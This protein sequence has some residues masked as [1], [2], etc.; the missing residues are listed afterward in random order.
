MMVADPYAFMEHMFGLEPKGLLER[1]QHYNKFWLDKDVSKIA[2]MRSPLT[3]RSE[4]DI[5]N[6]T[7]NEQIE[8]W[9]QYLNCCCVFNVHGVDMALLC[10]GV[11]HS[12]ESQRKMPRE[13]VVSVPA[14][15]EGLCVSNVFQTNMVLQRDKPISVW[16][17]ADAGEKLT[18]TFGGHEQQATAAE[19][20]SWKVT[21]PAMAASSDPNTMIV[22]GASKSLTLEGTL[23]SAHG[24]IPFMGSDF[25]IL[26]LGF[27]HG[28]K[29]TAPPSLDMVENQVE[30]T[31]KM[32]T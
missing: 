16:G 9:Y 25:I 5:L 23:D 30:Q 15:G 28:W 21:L 13:D 18:V 3:W 10:G 11:V 4:V 32:R 8:D 24:N 6:L 31:V 14:I 7:N 29:D 12:Q 2:G 22:K 1:D 17:W 26:I 27:P 19:D 20:R